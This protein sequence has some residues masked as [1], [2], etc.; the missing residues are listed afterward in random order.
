MAVCYPSARV[1]CIC[2]FLLYLVTFYFN[3]LR[4]NIVFA[5]GLFCTLHFTD[6]LLQNIV[7]NHLL[8]L[9][10]NVLM[11]GSEV[12]TSMFVFYIL[13]FCCSEDML[14]ELSL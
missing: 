10:D 11:T 13:Y 4:T 8:F 7:S 6:I 3:V 14:I 2:T 9:E 5:F 12:K 1:A